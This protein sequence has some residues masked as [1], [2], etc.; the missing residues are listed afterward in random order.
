[1]KAPTERDARSPANAFGVRVASCELEY[2]WFIARCF[3]CI[4]RFAAFRRGTCYRSANSMKE[5]VIRT[6]KRHPWLIGFG[7]LFLILGVVL[8]VRITWEETSLTWQQG[9]QM[10]GFSL[11]HGYCAPL[12]AAPIFLALWLAVTIIF[13]IVDRVKKFAANRAMLTLIA[14]STLT[15]GILSLP[16]TFWQWTFIHSFSA[17][18]HAGDLMTYDAAQGAVRTVRGYLDRGVP[19]ETR[20]YEG[21]TA[22]FTA[23]AGGSV[24]VLELLAER[25][26]NLNA[27]NSYGDSPLEAAI[28]NKHH[29][30]AKFLRDHGARQIAGTPEQR[31]AASK[32]IVDREIE[33]EKNWH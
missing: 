2:R 18:P 15:L 26:A 3:P 16:E 17:S 23:A 13:A 7:A 5:T 12:L 28:G 22:A 30:A 20:N 27:T 31:D 14:V 10:I 29:E 11:A 25:K 33:R 9:P 1:M 6:R 32:A 8:A 24:A 4:P 19:I 21:S